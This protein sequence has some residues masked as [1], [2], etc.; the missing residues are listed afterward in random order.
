MKKITF[1][2]THRPIIPEKHSIILQNTVQHKSLCTLNQTLIPNTSTEHF[3]RLTET[4]K[5]FLGRKKT[6]RREGT[7]AVDGGPRLTEP[8]RL[9]S[10]RCERTT[11][12]IHS[13][14]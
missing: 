9:A 14:T 10:S 8:A 4:W 13:V 6:G 7:R 2:E 5:T 3:Q 12:T 11:K 1:L